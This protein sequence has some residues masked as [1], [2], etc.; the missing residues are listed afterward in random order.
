MDSSTPVILTALL[1][2]LAVVIIVQSLVNWKASTR[3]R[4]LPP[5]PVPLPFVG[6][7]FNVSR[8]KP[9][10]G[11]KELCAKYGESISRIS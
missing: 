11:Y 5:G 6:N 7:L 8:T 4:P 1:C 10:I 2:A 9:W 3:G